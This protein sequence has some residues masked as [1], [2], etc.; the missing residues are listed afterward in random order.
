MSISISYNRS[1][2]EYQWI[3][4]DGEIIT[5]PAKAKG[6]LF[7]HAVAVLD[8]ELAR[9]ANRMIEADPQLERVVWRGVEIVANNGV[10]VLPAAPAGV[11]AMVDSSDAYGRYALETTAHG[12]TCQCV[13]FN[14]YPTYSQ[15]GRSVC[16]HVA[17]FGL[18]M[19]TK[20]TRF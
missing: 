16:K 10:E 15:D 9:A 17:A 5:A 19:A 4:P 2:R 18:H 8:P 6:E 3:S 13:S 12:L 7:R 20:E 1:D 14:E 11:V